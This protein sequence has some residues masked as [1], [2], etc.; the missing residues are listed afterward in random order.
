MKK[1]VI[2]QRADFLARGHD[3]DNPV[4]CASQ[5]GVALTKKDWSRE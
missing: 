2:C 1:S 3:G 4:G 5:R